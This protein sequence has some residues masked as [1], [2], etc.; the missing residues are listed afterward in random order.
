MTRDNMDIKTNQMQQQTQF[1]VNKICRACLSE[2]GEMRSVFLVEESIGQTAR[3]A[4][5]IMG[6]SSVQVRFLKA[7]EVCF[8]LNK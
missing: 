3:L 8:L 5:M 6:F 7:T 2:K 1:D 4:E